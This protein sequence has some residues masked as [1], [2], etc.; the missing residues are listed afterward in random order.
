M[1]I[2]KSHYY[3]GKFYEIFIDWTLKEIRNIIIEQIENGS[4][5]IDIGCGTGSLVFDLAKKCKS[6]MGVELSS[7]MIK[8]A[9]H[10]Q[11]VNGGSNVSFVYDDA[12]DLPYF[13]D[14]Q[15]DYL[16]TSMVLHEMPSELRLKV[17]KEAK[18]IAKKIIIADYV[19]P[20]PLSFT[21]MRTYIVEFLAG[22]GHFRAFQD[23]QNNKG[24]DLLLQNCQLYSCGEFIN[25][26]NT[27]RVVI[28]KNK[29][30]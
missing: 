4:K 24:I 13:E 22:I 28:A 19:V 12:T 17:L 9:K 10:R 27:L 5:I 1:S 6:V 16:I 15:F 18:R 20:Q 11:Q 7:K 8:H 29:Q 23:F 26:N 3:D 30:N 25:Q 21:G 14:Q 2:G